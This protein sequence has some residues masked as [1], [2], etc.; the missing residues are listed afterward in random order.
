MFSRALSAGYAFSRACSSDY[1]FS[2]AWH[3]FYVFSRLLRVTY[4]P[5]L[6]K[7]NVFSRAY[8]PCNAFPRLPQ[9]LHFSAL[10]TSFMFSR[11]CHG[12]HHV[13]FRASNG[14]STLLRIEY[15][16]GCFSFGFTTA[17]KNTALIL[18]FILPST[19]YLARE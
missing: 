1:T 17:V 7:S 19:G 8:L 6:S 15:C 18:N 11:T 10:A 4:F 9:V 5:A 13:F 3:R 16:C 2:R 14:L 12:N